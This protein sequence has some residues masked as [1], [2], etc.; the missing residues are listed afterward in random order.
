MAIL[1]KSGLLALKNVCFL[2]IFWTFIHQFCRICLNMRHHHHP[3]AATCVQVAAQRSIW[4]LLGILSCSFSPTASTMLLESPTKVWLD[5]PDLECYLLEDVSPHLKG[6]E[7]ELDLPT[8]QQNPLALGHASSTSP[9]IL[10]G[11]TLILH[12]PPLESPSLNIK[13]RFFSFLLLSSLKDFERL[14]IDNGPSFSFIF[15]RRLQLK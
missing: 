14:I 10:T 5:L 1:G 8:M 11:L 4:C 12:L 3:L 15:S 13:Q 2:V 7:T 9:L 6:W